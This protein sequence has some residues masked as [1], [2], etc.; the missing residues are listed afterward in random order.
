MKIENLICEIDRPN[1]V[2]SGRK[3]QGNQLSIGEHVE[4]KDNMYSK[5]SNTYLK[6]CNKVNRILKDQVYEEE[7][8]YEKFRVTN[9]TSLKILHKKEVKPIHERVKDI[10]TKKDKYVKRVQLHDN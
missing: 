2:S 5:L 1:V 4:D 9:K 10:L 7:K 6:K 8:P 3:K